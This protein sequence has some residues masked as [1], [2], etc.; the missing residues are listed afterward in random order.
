MELKTITIKH[1]KSLFDVNIE[2]GNVNVFIGANG[3]GKSAFL[4]AVGILSAAVYE[5]VNDATLSQRGV[6]MGVPA[7]F[8]SSFKKNLKSILTIKLGASWEN[9]SGTW[10]YIVDLHNPNKNPEPDWQYHS[11]S[12]SLNGEMKLGRSNRSRDLPIDKYRGYF[13]YKIGTSEHGMKNAE[14]FY[15]AF[16]SYGIYSPN[17]ST[18]RGIQPDTSQRDPLGLFGGR[19]PEAVSFLLEK[20]SLNNTTLRELVDWLEDVEVGRP[21]KE[22]LSPNVPIV[23]QVI[24]FADR[25]MNRER[26]V[27]TSYDASEGVLYVL[28]VLS[29]AAHDKT[30]EIFAIDNFDNAMNPRL[31]K[32]IT[33]LFS[34]KVIEKNKKT[35]ITTHNPLVLDGLDLLDDRIRLFVF[36]RDRNGFTVVNRIK[37]SSRILKGNESLS[38]LWVTGR[39]GGVP[40]I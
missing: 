22:I 20:K 13:S 2:P 17:T 29:L 30:P 5:R 18:L 12:L 31:A 7:M 34:Q 10:E 40:N 37:V 1:F 33:K 39:L 24:K 23:Q 36:D 25:F 8:K 38:R 9:D 32:N 28:F 21:T 14:D 35:F 16:I 11:E 27:L 4:E 6:R 26:N 19:L 15:R 3:A